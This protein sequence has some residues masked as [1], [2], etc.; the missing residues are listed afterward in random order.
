MFDEVLLEAI[1][2]AEYLY[3]QVI[4]RWGNKKFAQSSVYDWV[5]SED[6]LHFC[7][8]LNHHEQ[9]QLR[10]LIM[11]K[12]HVKPWPWY[13]VR[14][15][16]PPPWSSK[17]RKETMVPQYEAVI[18]LEVHAELLTQ[19]K[20]F[21]ESAAH[22][23][24]NPNTHV[25]PVSLGL[26]GTLPVLNRAVLDMAIKAGLATQCQIARRTKFDRK[27]YFYP[28]LPKGYQITQY[29]YPIAEHGHL[30][31]EVQE[32]IRQ[33]R[34]KRIHMEEDAG[35]LVHA[36]ADRMAGSVYSLVDYNRAGVPLL[37]IVSEPDLRTA[38]EARIYMEELRSIL[39]AIGVCDGKMQE[40]SMRCD[41][42]ISLRPRGSETLG[43]RVEI[44]N[45]N[46]FKFLQ[47][48]VEYEI[49]RQ[50]V[51]LESGE[52]I[53]Q[54]TRL[55][56]ENSNRT[57]SMRSKEEAHDYRYFP[58]PDL[59]WYTVSE[60]QIEAARETLPELP[61]AKRQRY[62]EQLGLT[63]EEAAILV[64]EA[65]NARFFEQSLSE[66]IAP[67]EVAKWILGDI[68]RYL[69]DKELSL[70]QT[71]LSP[72]KLRELLQLLQAGTLSGKMAKTLLPALM[73]SDKDPPT[74]M[75]ELG[76]EQISDSGE[77]EK[78]IAEIV[79]ANPKQV[80]QFLSGKEKILGFFMGQVM[81]AT[82]GQ[83]D[84]GLTTQLLRQHLEQLRNS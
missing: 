42:N 40:G 57:L 83:A 61:A 49:H 29:D 80:A 15:T 84:P 12:F 24:G 19:A 33:I 44:K 34:L 18:G 32:H 76:L 70:S 56:D 72:E 68:S 20:I 2:F 9:G 6:F 77:L 52:E 27:H 17:A 22:F 66:D 14:H 16:D 78:I 75:Q 41:A 73:E 30:D 74:L 5:W 50:T 54:E 37:E 63:P 38:E 65:E 71:R 10:I 55:W 26:P 43:T 48:A 35:K 11:Q 13:S 51:A 39:V 7:Q 47:K 4:R 67:R 82:R 62:T 81:K 3:D 69:N 28:D 60:A 31:V 1:A 45:I 25:S 23:G 58:D 59:V 46:S 21:C 53:V 79:Q 64:A 8:R 36:G